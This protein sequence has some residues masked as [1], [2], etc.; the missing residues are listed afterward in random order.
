MRFGFR[1]GLFFAATAAVATLF[2]MAAAADKRVALVIGNSG[3]Q[4]VRKLGNPVNDAKALAEVFRT[5]GFDT[6][7]LRQDLGG[8]ELRRAIRDFSQVARDA[9]VA[10]VFYAGHGLEFEG[11]NYL[12]PIDAKL[13]WDVDIEDETTSLDRVLKMIEPAKRLRL[14]ILD[15]CRDNPFVASMKRSV[16]TRAVSRGLAKVEPVTSDTLIAFAAKAGSTADDGSGTHSPFTTA[17]LKHLAVPGLD[18]RFAFGR[19]RDDVLKTT[20][21]KQ[22]PFVYGSLGGDTI[23]I[24]APL[25]ELPRPRVPEAD[26]LTWDFLKDSRDPTALQQFVQRFPTSAFRR[27][28]EA[29]L[30]ALAAEVEEARRKAPP[31]A[32]PPDEISWTFLKAS[33][34]ADQ[35]RRFIE[36][37]PDSAR[38]NEAEQRVAALA[39]EAEEAKRTS[40]AAPTVDR[41]EFARAL[42][43]ELKRVGCF[44]GTVDGEFGNATRAALRNFAKFAAISLPDQD[45]SAEAIQAVRGFDKRICPLVC[46][47][48]ERAEGERCIRIVCGGGQVLRNGACISIEPKRP[49]SARREAA[50]RPSGGGKCFTFQGRQFCE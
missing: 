7:D 11:N 43:L 28:A 5:A 32:P 6:V 1:P 27:E 21:N 13:E 9:D 37:F 20:R 26:E 10:V 8:G 2:P 16:A 45:A 31:P 42:Q 50:P 36:Q 29:R 25:P 49:A 22:E 40:S 17:L 47:S 44:D 35:L 14:V 12:V 48:G 19:V 34:D 30:T 23:S 15:A 39:A 18:L 3:Y 41:R 24:V 38:R 33:K 46:P 4:K